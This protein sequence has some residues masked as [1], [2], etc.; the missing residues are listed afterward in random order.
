MTEQ[1]PAFRIAL[2]DEGTFWN[3]YLASMDSMDGALH[4]GSLRMSIVRNNGKARQAF[5]E[6]MQS[7]MADALHDLKIN[8]ER[9]NI[10]PAPE[11]ERGGR[12]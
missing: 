5:I 4:I 9:F 11:A 12:A 10:E 7:V 1:K 8:V 6:L 3:A 2:R